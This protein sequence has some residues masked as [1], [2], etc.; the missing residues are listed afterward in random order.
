[1]QIQSEYGK[2]EVFPFRGSQQPTVYLYIRTPPPLY[3]TKCPMLLFIYWNSVEYQ[4]DYCVFSP[5]VQGGEG[6]GQGEQRG[7]LLHF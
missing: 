1:M 6:E 4:V 2:S 3:E 5:G 7:G